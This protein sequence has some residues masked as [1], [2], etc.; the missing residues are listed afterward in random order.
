MADMRP[1]V[2]NQS[3]GHGAGGLV[4]VDGAGVDVPD[5]PGVFG[6]GAVRAELAGVG[7]VQDA[8]ARPAGGVLEDCG[9][10]LLA[11]DIGV[12][13]VEDEVAVAV[14]EQRT[15][16][17]IRGFL[18]SFKHSFDFIERKLHADRSSVRTG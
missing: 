10:L 13:L 15:T 3:G 8:H 2:V 14:G 7:D 12:K 4:S 1:D 9:D 5:F 18:F 17:L 11:L 16:S 6:D